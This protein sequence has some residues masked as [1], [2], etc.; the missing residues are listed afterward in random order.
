MR[1]KVLTAA[2]GF[3]LI[4]AAPALAEATQARSRVE[5]DFLKPEQF[6]DVRYAVLDEL[7][8]YLVER[9]QGV[10]PPDQTL[11]VEITDVRLAGTYEWWRTPGMPSFRVI[12]DATPPRITLRFTLFDA[13]GGVLS[14]GERVLIDQNFVGQS[15]VHLV[16]PLR[17]EKALLDRWLATEF[18]SQ[19]T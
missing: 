16:G 9:A 14:R 19:P 2:L 4:V 15:L 1:N 11:V 3:A 7:K 12:Q 8:T 13:S 18:R 6:P 17:Y 10:V 5:V